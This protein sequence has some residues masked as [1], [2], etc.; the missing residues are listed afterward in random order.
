LVL[1]AKKT[2]PANDL[3]GLLSWLKANPDKATL[4]HGGTGGPGHIAPAFSS[5]EKRARGFS[6]YL[7]AEPLRPSRT[8]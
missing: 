2:M 1:V 6:W 8:W 5:K 4:G 3:K 7:I